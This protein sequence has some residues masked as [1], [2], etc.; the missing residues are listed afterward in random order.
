MLKKWPPRQ[1]LKSAI[2]NI[3]GKMLILQIFKNVMG[4]PELLKLKIILDLITISITHARQ[5]KTG[6]LTRWLNM[7]FSI[8]PC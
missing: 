7:N 1:S 2:D 6:K 8:V 3:K 4:W 5:I